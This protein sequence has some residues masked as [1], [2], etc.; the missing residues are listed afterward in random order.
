MQIINVRP[1]SKFIRLLTLIVLLTFFRGFS[2]TSKKQINKFTY[3]RITVSEAE[4]KGLPVIKNK[5]T[6]TN[7]TSIS[8]NKVFSGKS[9]KS[10]N[11]VPFNLKNKRPSPQLSLNKLKPI[12]GE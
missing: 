2:Q 7:K 10:F 6:L 3:S 12:I 9:K 11:K 5:K 8:T 4:N 1:F